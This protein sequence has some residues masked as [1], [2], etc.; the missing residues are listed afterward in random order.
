M[1]RVLICATALI[2]TN[3]KP[4]PPIQY[5]VITDLNQG[6]YV[7][8]IIN[9]EKRVDDN[10]CTEWEAVVKKLENQGVIKES[11]ALIDDDEI[12]KKP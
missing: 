10:I 8:E 4:N 12:N 3:N 7:W 2:L 9:R 11:L 6:G 5:Y 1:I